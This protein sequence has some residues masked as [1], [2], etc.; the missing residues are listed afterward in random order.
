MSLSHLTKYALTLKPQAAVTGAWRLMK[1]TIGG[2]FASAGKKRKCS[3]LHPESIAANSTIHR[4]FSPEPELASTLAALSDHYI[5]HRFNLLGSGW[6]NVRYD[7][8][9]KGFGKHQY[10][11]SEVTGPTLS[12]P[13]RLSSGNQLRAQSIRDLI[14]SNYQPIDW[15]LDFKSGYRWRENQT[16]ETI[17]YGHE[18]GVDIKVPW[19]LAR[20]QHLPQL[21]LAHQ[22]AINITTGFRR[23]EEYVRE[24]KDQALDFIAANPPGWGVNWVC[25]MDVAIRAANMVLAFDLFRKQGITFDAKFSGE[26]MASIRAHGYHIVNNL[27]WHPEHRGNH[28]L[29]DITGLLFIARFLPGSQETDTW[30]AFAIQ[31]LKQECE[32]QFQNDGSNFEAS[33]SYHRLS[34][35]MIIYGTALVLGLP[36]ERHLSLQNI[37]ASTWP[38]QPSLKDLNWDWDQTNGPFPDTHFTRISKMAEFSIRITRPDGCVVQIGDNDS[39]RFF[40]VSPINLTNDLDENHLDHRGLVAAINGLFDRH[41]FSEFSGPAFASETELV[42]A[43]SGNHHIGDIE[44]FA[45]LDSINLAAKERK[46]SKLNQINILLPDSSLTNG[47]TAFAY[48]D[49]GL[50]IWRSDRLFLSVRCGSI[51]QTGRGGHAH[52]DQLAIELQIDEEDWIADPGSFVYTA[53]A[54]LRDAYRSVF[55]HATPRFGTAEPS[56]LGL[57]MFRLE[58][59]ANAHCLQFNKDGFHGVH[60][61]YGETVFRRIK[62][63][64]GHIT[65]LDGFGGN[66]PGDTQ[67]EIQTAKNPEDLREVFGL[68]LPFSPGYGIQDKGY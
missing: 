56:G 52:N 39:G 9:A 46:S 26:F 43:F 31:E 22:L 68:N 50:Y 20:L 29:A 49:F 51:G 63:S 54:K 44:F 18:A 14:S 45:A 28:Y 15:Q 60:N 32:R 57:G 3:F 58:D 24:F 27:E 21:A 16:S 1:R 25:T 17:R 10:S 12:L 66:V 5:G 35:E 53:N 47:L 11:S 65:L 23:S 19:E 2:L 34:A 38:H 30:L 6:V 40:K 37:T 42:R 41:D 55:A 67:P 59:N 48:P 7:M 8:R 61:A 62:I 33:T 64:E 13:D 4:V 36:R